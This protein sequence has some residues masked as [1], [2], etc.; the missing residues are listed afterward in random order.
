MDRGPSRGA[1]QRSICTSLRALAVRTSGSRARAQTPMPSLSGNRAHLIL[2]QAPSSCCWRPQHTKSCRPLSASR[3]EAC[4]VYWRCCWCGDE[5]SLLEE[6][7]RGQLE[8]RLL[9][10]GSSPI[11]PPCVH[12]T[13]HKLLPNS[14]HG[15]T[16]EGPLMQSKCHLQHQRRGGGEEGRR[17]LTPA[18][19]HLRAE[20]R[21]FRAV[22]C[23]S[24]RH[25]AMRDSGDY[26]RLQ[27]NR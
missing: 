10:A 15:P 23:P 21:R 12:L 22:L 8:T 25:S 3:T 17:G 16:P 19:L 26:P 11:F 6:E 13:S 18:S 20:T 2:L 27:I 1:V 4:R 5:G 9:S 24:C 7:I 14:R